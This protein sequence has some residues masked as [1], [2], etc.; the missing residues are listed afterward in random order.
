MHRL[1]LLAGT[2]LVGGIALAGCGSP[3]SPGSWSAQCSIS[4]IPGDV[5]AGQAAMGYGV[6]SVL[7]HNTGQQALDPD[8]Y[9]VD[10]FSAPGTQTGSE[11]VPAA[12]QGDVAPGAQETFAGGDLVPMADTCSLVSAAG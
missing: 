4:A 9:Q 11:N 3:T 12:W 5:T 7:I 10:L 6:V 2:A 8:N 1:V